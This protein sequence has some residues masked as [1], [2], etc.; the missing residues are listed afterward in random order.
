MTYDTMFKLLGGIFSV[1]SGAG[2][3]LKWFLPWWKAN[4]QKKSLIAGLR[5]LHEVYLKMERLSAYGAERVVVFG[6]HNSGGI[7]RVGS[8]F[9]A[10]ALHWRVDP[11]RSP[12]M[13]DYNELQVDTSYIGMLVHI[14][15]H[16][17]Y[18]FDMEK[19]QN[20]LLRRYYEMEGVKD[21][22]IFYLTCVDN[23][24]LYLS[25]ASYDRKFTDI[26]ISY[27]GLIAQSIATDIKS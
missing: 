7:P 27:M 24:I 21:S 26:E 1:L 23:T 15:Q 6:G 5:T 13:A 2:A 17:S 18:R 4:A 22:V 3:W 19:D 8:P 25:C 11:K 10:T 14:M 20:C 12:G 9:Y 16:G